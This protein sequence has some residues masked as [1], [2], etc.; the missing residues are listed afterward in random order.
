MIVGAALVRFVV[1]S[2]GMATLMLALAT[3]IALRPKSRRAR[4]T[5]FLVAA[6]YVLASLHPLSHRL[7]GALAGH[8][9][10][11]TRDA[12]PPGRTAIVLLGSGAFTVTDWSGRQQSLIDTI[13]AERTLEAARIFGLLNDAWII[14]SG[15]EIDPEDPDE[16]AG[17]TMKQTL[18][19]LGIPA[20]RILFEDRSKTTRDEAVIV[21]EMLAPL[22]P[23]SVVLVT[24]GFHMRRSLAVF[25]SVGINAIP[26]IA[27][28]AP[29]DDS[30]MVTYLPSRWALEETHFAIH[31][32]LG[33]AYYR[34]RGW[35]G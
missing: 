10:P 9:R 16:T 6:F 2:A 3:W 21:A 19:G 5:L 23:A 31:E 11:F 22:A 12:V 27:R 17:T 20:D 33:L 30:W 15:G 7:S 29:H 18:I 35:Q 1:S 25:R 8:F 32:L 34:L 13:G 26:A 14:S 24:S 4:I 28:E